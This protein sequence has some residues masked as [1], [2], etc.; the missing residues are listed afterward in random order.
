MSRRLNV[1]LIGLGRLGRVYGGYLAQRV[2]QARLVAVADHKADAA[3]QFAVEYEIPKWYSI[4]QELIEDPDVEAVAIVTSTSSH[5]RVVLDAIAARKAIFCEKP[6]ALALDDACQMVRAA[7]DAGVFLQMGFQR[8]F[9]AGYVA[10]RRKVEDGLIGTPVL[11][12]SISRDPYR[13]PVEFCDPKISGGM[14]AD[15]GAHDFDAA[16]MYMGEVAKVHALG[17]TLAYPELKGVG[18]I[19]N[20]V[21]SLTFESGTLGAVELSRNAVFGYDIRGEIW[22][23]KGSIQIGYHRQTPI[24]LM[25]EQGIVHDVVPYFMERFEDAYLAQIRSFVREV[26]D[27]GRPMVGGEDAIAALRI[28]L[29]ANRSLAEGR[30]VELRENP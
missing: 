14:I 17:A 26:L 27:G 8:R 15:M 16:R 7:Q 1:G 30:A 18:D 21:I 22:G 12:T 9:D 29:A 6:I 2:P 13:P 10:A 23:T 24:L 11:F 5:P 4:H 20:A 25:T 19:D 28:S 3:R